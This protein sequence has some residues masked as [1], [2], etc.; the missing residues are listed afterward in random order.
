MAASNDAASAGEHTPVL[1]QNVLAALP[2]HAAGRYIDGT[3][4]AGGHASGILEGSTP[5]G[6]LLG[7]DRDPRALE[8]AGERLAPYEGRVFLRRG[9]YAQ[10]HEYASELGWQ[11]VD[12]ILLD[13]G[14][15]SMQLDEAGRGFSFQA[16]GPLDMRFGPDAPTSASR[17][18]NELEVEAL[19]DIIWRYGEESRSRRIARAI[20]R[21]RPLKTTTELAE[22]VARAVGRSKR[23]LHPATKTFQALRIAVNEEL[24]VL[25]RGLEIGSDLLGPGGRLVVISF[26][27]LED[28]IVKH[29]FRQASKDCICPPE[30]PVC[31]CDHQASLK[32]ITPRPIR[33]EKAE[34]QVNPRSRSAKMRVAERLPVA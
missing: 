12:G 3:V 29:F 19:A 21:A 8:I 4:G 11:S 10:M 5:E 1:Y 22:V 31:V 13:L 2:L 17:L 14:L 24:E 18:V 6:L 28:R 25:E 34:I 7:L 9:S 26:H 20:E 27:S 30:T 33:P 15:S 23:G 32:V 16:E